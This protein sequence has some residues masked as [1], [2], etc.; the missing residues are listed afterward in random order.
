VPAI[1]AALSKSDLKLATSLVQDEHQQDAP[2]LL[3]PLSSDSEV[4]R[5]DTLGLLWHMLG[6]AV[7]LAPA[8]VALTEATEA[9][10][11]LE[12]PLR[13]ALV[14]SDIPTF[15][16]IAGYV[17]ANLTLNGETT[18]ANRA[19]GTFLPLLIPYELTDP[20]ADYSS[21]VAA[22][23]E[24]QPHVVVALTGG[25]FVARLLRPLEALGAARP[26]FYVLGHYLSYRTELT[27]A[28][29]D[30]P[31]LQQRIAGVNF[32]GAED[33]AALDGYLS[34]FGAEYLGASDP[35]SQENF[36]DAA[37]F[38]MYSIAAAGSVTPF[39]G[40]DAVRGMRRLVD[41][42]SPFQYEV[43]PGDMSDVLATLA[44]TS[45]TRL[46]LTGTLGP[47]DWDVG[48]GARA[49]RA[50]VWCVADDAGFEFAYDQMRYDATMGGFPAEQGLEACGITGF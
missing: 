43:G 36:Y 44:V 35:T 37:Y 24:F 2:F 10:L 8:F 38:L 5:A 19:N 25:E 14:Y 42:T 7:D 46:G 16:D 3:N 12:E 47:P 13:L 23:E 32:A 26:R 22:L 45:G 33:R 31:G 6:S 34:R 48:T 28:A 21:A 15:T 18:A 50:S 20:D 4:E 9:K 11:A 1:L 27:S 39:T 49:A 41:P 40:S 29:N 30:F 17:E